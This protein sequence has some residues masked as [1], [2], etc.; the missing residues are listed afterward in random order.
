ME[1]RH[2]S[3]AVE[4]IVSLAELLGVTPPV[5]AQEARS[6][7]DTLS[8]LVVGAGGIGCEVLKNLA[9]LG[10]RTVTA[11]RYLPLATARHHITDNNNNI[12]IIII[13]IIIPARVP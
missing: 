4:A 6:R 12:I 10:V 8:V 9:L 11:V 13:I 7:L 5:D 2:V 1:A 3:A